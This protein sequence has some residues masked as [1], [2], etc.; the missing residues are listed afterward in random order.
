MIGNDIIDLNLA[1]KQSN[2]QRRGFLQKIFTTDEQDFILNAENPEL[3]VWLLWSMKESVYKAVQRKYHLE[4]FNNPKRFVC[5]QVEINSGKARGVVCFEEDAC[6]INS[7]LFS[8]VIHTCTANTEFSF[9]SENKNSRIRLLQKISDQK[10]IPLESL[11]ISKNK[12][13]VPFLTYRGDNLQIPFS[14]SHHGD[15]SAFALSLNL[16]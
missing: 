12:Q 16:S 11:N 15:Y 1:F 8:D 9:I 14:L 5:K 10:N 6:E 2:W 7:I 13:G 4:P 3:N